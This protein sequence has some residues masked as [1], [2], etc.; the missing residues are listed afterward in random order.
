[1]NNINII[2]K[3][4]S[5]NN[6]LMI[7]IYNI[8]IREIVDNICN[9]LKLEDIISFHNAF[10]YSMS[11]KW[12]SLILTDLN[13]LQKE[14]KKLY[15]VFNHYAKYTLSKSCSSCGDKG[16]GDNGRFAYRTCNNCNNTY[17][18]D[19]CSLNCYQCNGVI[20]YKCIK[21]YQEYHGD[22]I[23]NNYMLIYY[24]ICNSCIEEKDVKHD[25]N[26]L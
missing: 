10:H 5:Y 8:L 20:C 1:M 19:Q 16:L 2:T 4:L 3:Y 9:F 6:I 22:N 23:Y 18:C 11:N 13:I 15:K 26:I 7:T 25:C 12:L 24:I 14:Q 17:I 21:S